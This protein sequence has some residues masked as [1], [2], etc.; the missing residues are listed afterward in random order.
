[1]KLA[2]ILRDLDSTAGD[3]CIVAR[4]PWSSTSE[5]MLVKLDESYSIPRHTSEAGYE[6]FLEV[7]VIVEEVLG[8]WRQILNAAQCL[9]V[10]L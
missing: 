5:A 9:Q 8:S 6:Y 7:H 3:L 4:R 1:M 2:D 10:V